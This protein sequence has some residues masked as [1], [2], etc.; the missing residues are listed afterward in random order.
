M[1]ERARQHLRFYA[2][3]LAHSHCRLA[4][5]VASLYQMCATVPTCCNAL[6]HAAACCTALQRSA[7]ESLS[8]LVAAGHILAMPFRMTGRCR[9]M[10]E[11]KNLRGS[12][13]LSVSHW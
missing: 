6:Q 13:S 11:W 5:Q 9:L 1:R 10:R 7:H 2:R 12:K 8:H 3:T 4:M